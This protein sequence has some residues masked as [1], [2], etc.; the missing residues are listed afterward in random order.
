MRPLSKIT[1][2]V[3][4]LHFGDSSSENPGRALAEKYATRS[5]ER[6]TAR[7]F[8]IAAIGLRGLVGVVDVSGEV[9]VGDQVTVEIW[10]EECQ[11]NKPRE[12]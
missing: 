7:H 2:R 4:F 5:G 8:P 10:S 3:E 6:L 9:H 12:H 1:G 11:I